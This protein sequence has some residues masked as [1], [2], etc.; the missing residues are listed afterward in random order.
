MFYEVLNGKSLHPNILCFISRWHLV[1]PYNLMFYIM[2]IF[3]Y[4]MYCS[5]YRAFGWNP[6]VYG[7]LPLILNADGSKLSKRQGDIKIESFRKQGIFPLALL[8]Y[9]I[10]AG[11]GFYKETENKN[12]LYSYQELIKKVKKRDVKLNIKLLLF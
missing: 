3:G 8:N 9:V 2:I 5:D 1:A 6:P 12:H 11:G 10:G 4:I 7:H